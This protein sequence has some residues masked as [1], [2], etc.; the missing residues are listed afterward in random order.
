MSLL[1]EECRRHVMDPS[2]VTCCLAAFDSGQILR[3]DT[4]DNS[5]TIVTEIRQ[6]TYLRRL[7]MGYKMREPHISCDYISFNK[8]NPY[9][10]AAATSIVGVVVLYDMRKPSS[11]IIHTPRWGRNTIP[12]IILWAVSNGTTII[13]CW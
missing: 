13:G 6:D 12:T 1:D 4:R 5:S 7:V 2:T 11:P 10:L 9:V 8:V 3:I